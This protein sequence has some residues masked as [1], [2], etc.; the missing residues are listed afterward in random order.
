MEIVFL[1]LLG[2]VAGTLGGLLGIGGSVIMI[3]AMSII[4]GWQFHLA[5]AVA[6][7]VNPMVAVSAA[8]KH[9]N[10]KNISWTAV[11]RVLPLSIICICVAAWL[12]NKVNSAWLELLFGTFLIWVLWDQILH[13]LGKKKHAETEPKPSVTRCATTGGIT[14]TTAGLLGIGGGLIQVPLLNTLCRLPIK[15]AIGTSSA[16]MFFTAII[17]AAVKDYSLSNVMDDAER[18]LQAMDAIIGSL[19]LVPGALVGGWFG[20]KLTHILPIRSIRSIFALL[21]VIASIKMLYSSISSL[22]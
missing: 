1:L 18:P 16:I 9:H 13:L 11:Q 3:P 20:A 22:I 4:L 15:Q 5:Q 7:T 14:G 2:L 6:M 8:S 21:V 12:S 19:W 10:Q 17:G